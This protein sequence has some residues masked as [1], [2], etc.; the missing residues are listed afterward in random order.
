[1]HHS[2]PLHS[3]G[4]Q[5]SQGRTLGLGEDLD[6]DVVAVGFG[7]VDGPF[8]GV[9]P[10]GKLLVGVPPG[11]RMLVGVPGGG[12]FVGLPGGRSFV[13]CPGSC[14]MAVGEDDVSPEGRGIKLGAPEVEVFG[15]G[16]PGLMGALPAEL[17]SPGGGAMNVKLEVDVCSGCCGTPVFIGALPVEFASPEGRGATGVEL[18]VVDSPGLRVTFGGLPLDDASTGG[19]GTVGS[20]EVEDSLGSEGALGAMPEEDAWLEVGETMGGV[21]IDVSPINGGVALGA[22]PALEDDADGWMP[23]LEFDAPLEGMGGAAAEELDG[24]T[25]LDVHKVL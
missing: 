1:M 18:K 16:T 19:E 4:H 9:P 13:V 14:G 24:D 23:G 11:G 22:N 17:A 20:F 7:P 21:A 15:C 8:V 2:W 12:L 10:G 5:G 3:S 25:G 6:G